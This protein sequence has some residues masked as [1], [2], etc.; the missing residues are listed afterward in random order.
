MYPVVAI[1]GRPNVGKSTLFNVFTQSRDALVVDLP[2]TTRDRQY[3]QGSIGEKRFIVIDTGGVGGTDQIVDDDVTKQSWLAI[4][5][6]DV[7]LFMVDGQAGV[8]NLDLSFAKQL[9]KISKPIHLVVNKTDGLDLQVAMGD[10]FSLGFADPIP[11]AASQKRGV[12]KLVEQV[13]ADFAQ[14]E[15]DTGEDVDN[16]ERFPGIRVAFVGQPNVGKSTLVNRILGE[17]RVIV[18]ELSG[19]TRDSIFIPFMRNG[20]QYTLIDTAGVRRK[21]KVNNTVEKFSVVKTLQS[22]EAANVVVLM[23]DATKGVTD[24][25]LHL[26]DFIIEA[27]RA[28]VIAVNKWDGLTP[29]ERDAVKKPLGYRL[30]FADFAIQHFISALHGSGVG[31]IFTSIK[32]AYNSAMKDLP[33]PLLTKLLEEIVTSHQPPL[34][35]GRRIKLRYA[36]SGGHN[37]QRIIIHGNMTAHIPDSYKRYMIKAFIDRLKLQGTPVVIQFKTGEN[38]Y[39][40]KKNILTPR[41]QRKRQRLMKHV[42]K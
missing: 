6:A 8:T 21:A 37:P 19:T 18:S 11:I 32:K 30:H 14:V 22:I 7:I 12:I 29:A 20:Q 1:V 5:E 27:G 13:L 38:P 4:S 10:F 2:G 15:E 33:T 34:V 9:R 26:L 3:G 39:A 24:Q 28:L 31:D 35:Q 23:I 41:Q 17:E 16:P 25:D 42:R 40:D 36:H